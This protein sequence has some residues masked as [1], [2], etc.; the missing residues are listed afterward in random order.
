MKP[1]QL[2]YVLT[3]P[4]FAAALFLVST[5]GHAQEVGE[6][7]KTATKTIRIAGYDYELPPWWD[8]IQVTVPRDINNVEKMTDYVTN[9]FGEDTGTSE[10]W[11][12]A[13]KVWAL[14]SQERNNFP[15][16]VAHCHQAGGDHE[17]AAQ[18]YADLYAMAGSQGRDKERLECYLAY[19]SGES[20]CELKN[21]SMAKIWYSRSAAHLGNKDPHIASCAEDAA[22]KLK[23]LNN[24]PQKELAALEGTWK[25]WRVLSF[26]IATLRFQ[27][28][29][30]EEVTV[31]VKGDRW[32]KKSREKTTDATI[33]I[34]PGKD[35]AEIDL[36][37]KT[38]SGMLEV[39][40]IYQFAG[41]TLI[42]ASAEGKRPTKSNLDEPE[43]GNLWV[44]KRQVK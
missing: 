38:P 23:F 15:V 32:T 40:G 10:N 39:L 14:W 28:D 13:L 37:Y 18:V 44:Y 36:T 1:I 5:F 6:K 8:S 4:L 20:Y 9:H 17:R 30:A 19:K 27:V 33:K 29:R 42:I 12:S 7:P 16:Y 35:P 43:R 31:T 26:S 34:D 2:R 21:A 41:D 25:G 11:K 24:T 22:K 3:T